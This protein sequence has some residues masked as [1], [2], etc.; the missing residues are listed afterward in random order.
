M[1]GANKMGNWKYTAFISYRHGGND[2]F[3][4]KTLHN[5]LEN[6]RVPAKLAAK[7]G[8][9]KVGR[10]FRDV[11]ELPSSSSLYN[12]IE[13]A[14]G[15]S[16][17]LIVICTPRLQESKW[18]MREIELFQK[19]RGS[20]HIIAVLAE[21]EPVDSFPY[22][23]THPVINGQEV[24]VEPLAA[25]VRGETPAK[26]K[27]KMRV[28]QL[29]IVAAMLHCEFDQLRQ[30]E[31][32]RQLQRGIAAGGVSFAVVCAFLAMS[33]RENQKLQKQVQKTQS[34]QSYLLQSIRIPLI[35]RIT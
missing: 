13:E 7:L 21:G 9:K 22:A 16:E 19:L 20:D 29:R 27:H 15:Q 30:R 2:E 33:V 17:F 8:R 5:M 10:I 25:D 34:A 18:C 23:I 14:L 11:D 32:Q 31:Q 1:R 28:E 26:Q 12:N 35:L 24:E 4:A 6:Y 3:A